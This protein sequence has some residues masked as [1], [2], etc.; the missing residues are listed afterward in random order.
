MLNR[1]IF[2]IIYQSAKITIFCEQAILPL[3]VAVR[4][5]DQTPI[6]IVSKE[7]SRTNDQ[8]KRKA[9]FGTKMYC[10]QDRSQWLTFKMIPEGA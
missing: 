9:I 10:N 4:L 6:A 8:S 3:A 1:Y 7:P 2:T 5:P